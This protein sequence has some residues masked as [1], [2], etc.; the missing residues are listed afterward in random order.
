MTRLEYLLRQS[1]AVGEWYRRAEDK[2]RFVIGLDTVLLGVVNGLVFVG[3]EEARAARVVRAAGRYPA[4]ARRSRAGGLLPTGAAGGA[5][6]SRGPR[7][8][9]LADGA[10]VVLRRYR[11]DEPRAASRGHGR[12]DEAGFER[13]LI[14]QNHVLSRH[15]AAKY[16]AVNRAAACGIVA[17]LLLFALGLVY[18]W[19]VAGAV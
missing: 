9:G 6:A 18:G 17:L 2:A 10:D 7:R 16:V 5:F 1:E 13:S 8:R 14:S 15:V 19:A 4:G 12:L 3:A 11:G